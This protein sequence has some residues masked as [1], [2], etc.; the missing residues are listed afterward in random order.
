MAIASNSSLPFGMRVSEPFI[1]A[2][3]RIKTLEGFEF[4]CGPEQMVLAKAR[5]GARITTRWIAAG[6]I[7]EGDTLALQNYRSRPVSADGDLRKGWLVG[8]C[9]GNGGHNPDNSGGTYLR[10]WRAEEESLIAYADAAI[11]ELGV[12]P[13]Y[14]GG[15]RNKK[16]VT[17]IRS[18]ALSRYIDQYLERGT[19]RPLASIYREGQQFQI[20]F[21]QGLFDS[22]GSAFGSLEKGRALR[23]S[24]ANRETL[25][26]VQNLL[27]QFGI[28]ARLYS[29]DKARV[30]RLPDG[31]GGAKGYM[32]KPVWELHIGK[33]NIYW[34]YRQI[35]LNKP[36]KLD[37]LNQFISSGS[38]DPYREYFIV[39]VK[40]VEI[41]RTKLV[42]CVALHPMPSGNRSRV[43]VSNGF[44]LEKAN[45]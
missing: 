5:H 10:F 15:N 18:A 40:S 2:G 33:D 25:L 20:G 8:H 16:N 4:V 22:D 28:A 26:F 19:K 11:R 39:R 41:I 44:V 12:G 29:R 24:Q 43:F 27:L 45:P 30:K 6:Q 3:L 7:Q 21:L 17:T 37:R 13:T 42:D 38:R 1:G 23:L 35:G 36:S 31:R 32:C 34:F 9:L 14:R